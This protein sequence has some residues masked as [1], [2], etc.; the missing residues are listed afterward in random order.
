M[1]GGV[2]RS[3]CA[4]AAQSPRDRR[5]GADATMSSARPVRQ[6]CMNPTATFTGVLTVAVPVSDQ[7]AAKSLFE[8]L[9]FDT[10]M[11]TELQPDFRWI[12]MGLTDGGTTISLVGA[13]KELPPGGDPGVPLAPADP[14]AAHQAV[15]EVGLDVGELLD[16]GHCAAHVLVCR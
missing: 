4:A 1:S 12:E 6:R 16:L 2:R 15:R 9:G 8:R 3:V 14:R 7:D 5:Q 10:R 13:G 11:D